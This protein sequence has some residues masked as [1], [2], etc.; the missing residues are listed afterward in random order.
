[1]TSLRLHRLALPILV[2]LGSTAPT[3]WAQPDPVR[4]IALDD[5]IRQIK[6]LRDAQA[7]MPA[8]SLLGRTSADH[9]GNDDLLVLRVHTLTEVGAA[10]EAWRQYR[11]R[12]Q[13]F[14]AQERMRLEADHYARWV[15]WSAQY[16]ES[17]LAPRADAQAAEDVLT[18]YLRDNGLSIEDL[19]P[20]TRLDRLVVL[21]RLGR[22]QEVVDEY[23]RIAAAHPVPGYAMAAVADAAMALQRPGQAARVLDAILPTAPKEDPA[24][25]DLRIQRAYAA[26][27]SEQHAQSRTI[28]RALHDEHPAWRL[29]PGARSGWENWPHYEAERNLALVH[30]FGED[31]SGAQQRLESLAAVAPANPTL[32]TS[33]GMVYMFRGWPGRAL[34]R[35][36]IAETLDERDLQ[37][38]IGQVNTLTTLQRDDLAHPIHDRL[39]ARYPDQL[40]VRR[41][42]QEWRIHRGWQWQAY[43][44]AGRSEG[45]NGLSPLGSRD[46]VYGIEVQ[47]P[48][49]DDRWRL[50]AGREQRWAEFHQQRIHDDRSSVGVVYAHDR[51]HLGLRANRASDNLGG[52]GLAM[53]AGWRFND[54]W[55]ASAEL[56]RNDAEGSMQ[57]RM[58][59]I[60]ADSLRLS[61]QYRPS[62]L[63]DWNASVSRLRYDDGNTRN[64]LSI[65]LD[66]RLSTH[67][68]FLLNGL[69]S[70]HAG[71]G[72]RDDA[73]YFNPSRDASLELGVR[74]DHLLWRRYDRHVRHRLSLGAGPAWQDGYGSHIVPA[75]RY[76]QQWQ[77]AL[78]RR[79]VYGLSWSRPVYDGQREERIGLDAQFKWGEQ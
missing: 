51:L 78:G 63:T 17:D 18:T 59:G 79:L 37:A 71:T 2:A 77:F 62:E 57:A 14:S 69:A 13:L 34:E 4:H 31:H 1:M 10:E 28:L 36:R 30:A 25:S 23:D 67:P 73:P 68:H 15:T 64:A 16:A 38:R 76:E 42:D 20:R 33:L 50:V 72:S 45:G 12:P 9:P 48:L 6:S 65:T 26:L 22:Y 40:A 21:N 39:L 54:L 43:G 60:T 29:E 75:A 61:A 47:S 19:P 27:E 46:R 56:R 35:Y 55:S 70:L 49:I 41:M 32:Q 24:T 7:W 11:Q 74:A 3:A 53:S 58:A 5:A 66:Q 44:G 52:A 8:L